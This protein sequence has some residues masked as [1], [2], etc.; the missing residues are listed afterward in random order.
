MMK[1]K[2]TINS[3][4]VYIVRVYAKSLN[5]NVINLVEILCLCA[6]LVVII[7]CEHGLFSKASAPN[8]ENIEKLI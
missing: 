6:F 1:I 7:G 8:L 2:M 4:N 3:H 5:K